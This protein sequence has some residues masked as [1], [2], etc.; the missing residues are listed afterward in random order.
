MKMIGGANLLDFDLF[1]MIVELLSSMKVLIYSITSMP[2]RSGIL[3]S[4]MSKSIV[5]EYF[6]SIVYV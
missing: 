3:N 1:F 6:Y 5:L 4:V 2:V